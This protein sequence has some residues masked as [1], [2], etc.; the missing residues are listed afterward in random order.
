MIVCLLM[1]GCGQSGENKESGDKATSSSTPEASAEVSETEES[2]SEEEIIYKPGESAK[3]G[4][5]SLK[6]G[7]IK[8]VKKVKATDF[9][10]FKPGD[11][12]ARFML[13]SLKV[14]NEGTETEK[15]LPA[16]GDRDAITAKLIC[17][18][19]EYGGTSLMGYKKNLIDMKIDAGKSKNGE[20]AFE[21]PSK[22]AKGKDE[23]I[24]QIQTVSGLDVVKFKVR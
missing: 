8:V 15:F 11:S 16:Y 23:L 7:K 5:W 21:L 2:E 19:E 1:A 6:A 3:L 17:G 10:Q 9:T 20:I 13:V 22:E 12:G 14:T 4:D 18:E 24:L